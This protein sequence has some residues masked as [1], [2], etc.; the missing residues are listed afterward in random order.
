MGL[1]FLGKIKQTAE[2]DICLSKDYYD[3][4]HYSKFFS[5]K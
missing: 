4:Q 1:I 5:I 2:V 3:I